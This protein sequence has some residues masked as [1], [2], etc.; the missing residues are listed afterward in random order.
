MR[1][2]LFRIGLLKITHD[3]IQ[4]YIISNDYQKPR[5]EIGNYYLKWDDKSYGMSQKEI[6]ELKGFLKNV[7]PYFDEIYQ[8]LNS[9]DR[10]RNREK[11]RLNRRLFPDIHVSHRNKDHLV[12]YDLYMTSDGST[13]IDR[14]ERLEFMSEDYIKSSK[15]TIELS[16]K[17]GD[18]E[19]FLKWKLGQLLFTR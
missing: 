8:L 11:Y 15:R 3:I 18:S 1:F 17:Y 2:S 7:I 9:L 19:L 10:P 13:F 14:T 5:I 6:S 4:Q 12:R 16:R